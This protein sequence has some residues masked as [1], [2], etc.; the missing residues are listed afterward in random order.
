MKKP[1]SVLE[2]SNH[3]NLHLSV[4]FVICFYSEKVIS[5]KNTALAILIFF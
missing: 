1:V 2:R 5:K 4:N 3:I